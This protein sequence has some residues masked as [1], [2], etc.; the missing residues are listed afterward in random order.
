MR[1]ARAFVARQD[2]APRDRSEA[3]PHEPLPWRE[4]FA[5]P[6]DHQRL[7]AEIVH[8][9]RQTRTVACRT[10]LQVVAAVLVHDAWLPA[11][12]KNVARK[13]ENVTT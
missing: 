4:A 1:P 2:V 5:Q 7:Q 8:A 3:A 11:S 13:Q 6:I 12:A 9:P 10:V